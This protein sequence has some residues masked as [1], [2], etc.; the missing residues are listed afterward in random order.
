MKKAF[1]ILVGFSK[2]LVGNNA[3][4]KYFTSAFIAFIFPKILTIFKLLPVKLTRPLVVGCYTAKY[5]S[6]LANIS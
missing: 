6:K 4:L 3:K 2:R 1:G 5:L